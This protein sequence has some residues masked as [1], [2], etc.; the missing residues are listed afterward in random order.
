MSM[1]DK[2]YFELTIAG[3]GGQGALT[4]GRLLAEAGMSTYKHVSYFPNYGA[5]MRGG[6]SECTIILS[7]DAISAP[8]MLEPTS[9]ILMGAAP[10]AE[11]EKRI[12]PGG[13]LFIDSSLVSR[14]V[15]REDLRVIYL[16]AVKSATDM[17]SN[18]V[19]NFIFLGAYLEATKAV[20]VEVIEQA[21]EKKLGGGRREA[22]LALDK[23]ALREG[24]RMVIQASVE[25]A[26]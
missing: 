2:P 18:Q 23:Q 26:A 1:N 21:L 10:L 6:E 7:N 14:K 22:L 5:S 15:T 8:L 25:S 4:I 20:S 3:L 24:M 17:G 16:P 11:F 9:V 13:I 19:A 12:R